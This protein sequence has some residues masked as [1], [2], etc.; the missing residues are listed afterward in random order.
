MSKTFSREVRS[1]GNFYIIESKHIQLEKNNTKMSKYFYW[2]SVSLRGLSIPHPCHHLLSNSIAFF[3]RWD[4]MIDFWN[5]AWCWTFF[6]WIFF[7]CLYNLPKFCFG[8][9]LYWD[10]FSYICILPFVCLLWSGHINISICFEV[11]A[12]CWRKLL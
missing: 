10:F 3:Y 7:F 8:I 12:Y 2:N 11:I 5:F 9:C 4:K 6:T 1:K